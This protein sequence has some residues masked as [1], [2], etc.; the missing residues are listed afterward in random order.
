MLP[1]RHRVLATEGT[2]M[3]PEPHLPNFGAPHPQPRVCNRLT[4][5]DG[6]R[7]GKSTE[8][9][10]AGLCDLGVLCGS[11]NYKPLRYRTYQS[12]TPSPIYKHLCDNNLRCLGGTGC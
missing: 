5:K 4:V 6:W 8:S 1:W 3:A 7:K 9:G 12:T 11:Y 10:G 2:E